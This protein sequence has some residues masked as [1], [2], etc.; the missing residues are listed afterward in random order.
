MSNVQETTVFTRNANFYLNGVYFTNLTMDSD[1]IMATNKVVSTVFDMLLKYIGAVWITTTPKFSKKL[2]YAAIF[3][4]LFGSIIS[5]LIFAPLFM[6]PYLLPM[7]PGA[8]NVTFL[9]I[10]G[11]PGVGLVLILI[12]FLVKKG[13]LV[14]YS[15]GK[16][17]FELE[18]NGVFIN[19][20][21]RA[22][23]SH[24]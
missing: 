12:Y 21:Y 14:I 1:R 6:S 10:F 18:G 3:I 24:W 11:P 7:M 15:T 23:R 4:S 13:C 22:L 20:V 17:T 16:E 8:A 2:L 9:A 5:I 19:D